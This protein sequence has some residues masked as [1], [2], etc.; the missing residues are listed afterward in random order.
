MEDKKNP[1]VLVIKSSSST[2][3]QQK[4]NEAVEKG[5]TLEGAVQVIT[6][7]IEIQHAGTYRKYNNIYVATLNS[8][9]FK[10]KD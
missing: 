10:I 2:N 8:H 7:G 3:I 1:R 4:I 5:Y 9:G 6:E